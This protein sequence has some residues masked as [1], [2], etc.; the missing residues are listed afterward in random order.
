MS[1]NIHFKGERKVQVISTG[2]IET[3]TTKIPN[4]WQTPTEVTKEI[5]KSNDPV[6]AYIDWVMSQSKDDVCLVYAKDDVFCERD[7]IGYETVNEA[8]DH[9]HGFKQTINALTKAGYTIITQ[10]W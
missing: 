6:Q 2:K 10:A 9:T 7:P 8:K 1:I 5:M 4:V 3:Q